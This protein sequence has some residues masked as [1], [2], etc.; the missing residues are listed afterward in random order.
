M[1]NGNTPQRDRWRPERGTA[2]RRLFL[3][4]AAVLLLGALSGTTAPS[5]NADR[6]PGFGW[7]Y[8]RA[9]LQADTDAIR[10][11]GASGVQALVVRRPG[12]SMLAVSGFRDITTGKAV[13]ANG[14][15]R[16][17]SNG[18]T[19]V[20]TVILQLVAER[21][22]SLDDAVEKHLPGLVRGN[23]HDGRRVTVRQLLQHTSGI[24][25]YTDIIAA[26]IFATE[27]SYLQRRFEHFEADEL[28]AA[29]MQMRPRFEP[30]TSWSYSNTNY[31][32]A[33]MI[34]KKV[35]GR[36]WDREVTDRIIE[37]LGLENTTAGNGP[38][39]P[40]PHARGYH[41]FT[42]DHLVDTTVFDPSWG[43]AAGD[44]IST[45]REV[46]RFFRALLGGDL[47]PPDLLAEMQRTIP[48]VEFQDEVTPNYR[49]GLGLAW[50]SLTC[51]GGYW[52]HGG[53]A[54]GYQSREGFS[55]D[56]RRSVVVST[57]TSRTDPQG[58]LAQTRA[59]MELI[60]HAL[61]ARH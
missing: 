5:A 48:A 11:T 16:I 20:S 9:D 45:P 44:V 29:A 60:D 38:H 27:E 28:V 17:G 54:P 14:H 2:M 35:T 32:L 53:D 37:P 42:P 25:N 33:G 55:E 26:S 1:S 4:L 13:I 6:L 7:G 10:A 31:A 23:G 43:G 61:C 19:F 40:E 46:D 8:G 59:T 51:G 36:T 18:K 58:S 49:Y 24:A 39:L 34:I 56:G 22:L 52:T 47:L 57:S 12:R 21:R 50:N 30:G 3:V 41:E 15:Y